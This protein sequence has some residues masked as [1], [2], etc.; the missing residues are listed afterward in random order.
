MTPKAST[1]KAV[2]PLRKVPESS[3]ETITPPLPPST[4]PKSVPQPLPPQSQVLTPVQAPPPT[5]IPIAVP[6]PVPQP[7][8]MPNPTVN[9]SIQQLFAAI[10]SLEQQLQNPNLQ[11]VGRQQLQQ[12]LQVHQHQL[13]QL[14]Q[15]MPQLLQIP[16]QVAGGGWMPSTNTVVRQPQSAGVAPL[17]GSVTQYKGGWMR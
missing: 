2:S 11:G 7:P 14:F 9:P 15:A 17:P 13:Q 1:P 6:V 3:L 10:A 5:A 16:Q 4:P 8:V 12:L